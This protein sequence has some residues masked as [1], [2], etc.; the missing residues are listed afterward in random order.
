MVV[1]EGR[2]AIE[3]KI[4]ISLLALEAMI[5]NDKNFDIAVEAGLH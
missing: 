3:K 4:N 5:V 2:A 1:N